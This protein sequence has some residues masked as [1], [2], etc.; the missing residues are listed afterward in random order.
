MRCN[1]KKQILPIVLIALN[2][3]FIWG[4][5]MLSKEQSHNLSAFFR[6]IL[7][8]IFDSSGG[9]DVI[10]DHTV[11]KAA[12]VFE[13]L[14]LGVLL[15]LFYGKSKLRN[16]L[17]IIGGGVSVAAIDETIQIFSGRGP[18]VKDVLIDACGCL[19]GFLIVMLIKRMRSTKSAANNYSR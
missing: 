14:V 15:T 9:S 17:M 16:C 4:N 8:G 2:I 5:S 12:H 6:D 13:F 3:L 1:A 11:R 19:I 7:R 10:S 18:A